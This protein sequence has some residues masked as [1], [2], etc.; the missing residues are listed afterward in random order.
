MYFLISRTT[1]MGLSSL[2]PLTRRTLP[3][4]LPFVVNRRTGWEG[5]NPDTDEKWTS[6]RGW[7]VL[8]L[9]AARC[10]NVTEKKEIYAGL[11]T[12]EGFNKIILNAG[13]K[14]TPGYW[15]MARGC[16]PVGGGV[17]SVISGLLVE[18]ARRTFMFAEEPVNCAAC[19]LALEGKDA[20]EFC[21]GKFGKAMGY[22]EGPSLKFP[23]GREVLFKDKDRLPQFRWGLQ[24][25]QLYQLPNADT[26]AMANRLHREC[27]KLHVSPNW[28][29]CDRTGNGAGVHDLLKSI[30]SEEVRGV[31]Y[32]EGATEK[33]IVEEDTK[34]CAEEYSLMVSELWFALKKWYEYNFIG[35]ASEAY[36]EELVQQLT[37]RRYKSGKVS[38]VEGKDD[39]KS[40]GNS[41]PN[42]ADA[43]TLLLHGVRMASGCVPSALD[44]IT[45]ESQVGIGA[46]ERGPCPHYVDESSKWR[47][48]EDADDEADEMRGW[49]E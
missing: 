13:G 19:D 31:N 27:V 25:E 45:P 2:G 5:F 16:F 30:W 36:S 38:R 21:K 28:F 37:G 4:R 26:V 9:D 29:M 40:R 20:A 8:R 47:S 12:L 7:R 23:K 10:E 42:K 39:Y 6:K 15:T 14:D 44:A 11:Q 17:Y 32:S 3:A 41:S 35:M 43:L 48:L 49:I 34:T 46:T 18:R 33:K 24:V 1:R 22:R